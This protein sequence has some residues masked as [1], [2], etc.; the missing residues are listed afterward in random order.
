MSL[1]RVVSASKRRNDLGSLFV[2]LLQDE[3]RWVRMAAFQALGPFIST[4]S[5]IETEREASLSSSLSSTGAAE[6]AEA[7]PVESESDF[8]SFYF[9]RDPLPQLNLMPPTNEMIVAVGREDQQQQPLVSPSEGNEAQE[10]VSDSVEKALE[11]LMARVELGGDGSDTTTTTIETATAQP[12]SGGGAELVPEPVHA[13]DLRRVACQELLGAPVA[14]SSL[15]N[16]STPLNGGD[17]KTNTNDLSADSKSADSS[18]QSTLLSSSVTIPLWRPSCRLL[19][20]YFNPI[21]FYRL[22]TSK[23]MLSRRPIATTI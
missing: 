6:S 17:D 4:F 12:A 7:E 23:V 15:D 13:F 11:D 1:S 22:R 9:W 3:S 8:N 5:R 10:S 14:S 19:R 2:N 16:S 21:F 20:L 18:V